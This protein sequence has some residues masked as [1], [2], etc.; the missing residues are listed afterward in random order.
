MESEDEFESGTPPG[1]LTPRCSESD[2]EGTMNVDTASGMT[3]AE[4]E[5]NSD[6]GAG[7]CND[8]NGGIYSRDGSAD[9]N[10]GLGGEDVNGNGTG[11]AS[12]DYDSGV[13]AGGGNCNGNADA[14]GE[15]KD[16]RS[17]Y[18]S[19]NQAAGETVE[20]IAALDGVGGGEMVFQIAVTGNDKNRLEGEPGTEEKHPECNRDAE[21]DE[22]CGSGDSGSNG[23]DGKPKGIF[24]QDSG[25]FTATPPK[26]ASVKKPHVVEG[27]LL[28]RLMVSRQW[29]PHTVR[30][31]ARTRLL[32]CSTPSDESLCEVRVEAVRPATQESQ[33]H[34]LLV[35]ATL[36]NPTVETT[37]SDGAD[38]AAAGGGGGGGGG[39][40]RLSA[41]GG[42]ESGGDEEEEFLL[43][44]GDDYQAAIWLKE[45][46]G[47]GYFERQL[48]DA[49]RQVA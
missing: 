44:A 23:G 36:V 3:A 37:R 2:D 43:R 15:G 16:G 10:D 45:L 46:R 38:A 8:A 27:V 48:W 9:V 49:K 42:S 18:D 5:A 40:G 1:S 25:E 7:S 33:P 39:G 47:E 19:V 6:G 26:V 28:K 12:A 21:E 41:A 11:S 35:F 24:E 32:A 17:L 31:D 29:K 34:C 20:T 22:S 30:F 14:N 13:E 4:L